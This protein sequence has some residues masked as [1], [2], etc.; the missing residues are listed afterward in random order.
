MR[1]TPNNLKNRLMIKLEG[2]GELD[3]EGRA[4]FVPES[5]LYFVS[6]TLL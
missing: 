4:K 5:I 6:L 1:Q 3:S 2:E